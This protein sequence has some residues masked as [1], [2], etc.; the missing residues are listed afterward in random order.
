MWTKG[1]FLPHASSPP[2][3]SALGA[4]LFTHWPL[5]LASFRILRQFKTLPWERAE[6]PPPCVCECRHHEQ[7]CGQQPGTSHAIV[8][9]HHNREGERQGS[10]IP[11]EATRWEILR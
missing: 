8:L 6:H 4:R 2:F 3:F 10:S 1:A 7:R 9:P 5:F 11:T